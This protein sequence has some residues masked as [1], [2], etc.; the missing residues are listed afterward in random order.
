MS[1]ND[2]TVFQGG[3][4]SGFSRAGLVCPCR[5]IR[6]AELNAAVSPT[7]NLPAEIRQGT[8][9]FHHARLETDGR[10]IHVFDWK[11]GRQ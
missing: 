6:V 9:V 2:K 1:D 11:E 4:F 3:P 8:Y 10:T 7:E 5:N